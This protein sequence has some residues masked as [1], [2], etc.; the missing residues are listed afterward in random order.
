MY[1][2]AKYYSFI[3]M[4]FESIFLI[5]IM[6]FKQKFKIVLIMYILHIVR[7]MVERKEFSKTC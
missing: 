7:S 5:L 6:L 3:N 2:G 1:Q 4:T